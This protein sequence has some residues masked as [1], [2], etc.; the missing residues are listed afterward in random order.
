MALWWIWFSSVVVSSVKTLQNG[1][2]EHFIF[3]LQKMPGSFGWELHFTVDQACCP[4]ARA[5]DEV[6]RSSD[7]PNWADG[8]TAK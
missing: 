8:W 1:A 4:A 3:A 2:R 6:Q 7:Q 5:P